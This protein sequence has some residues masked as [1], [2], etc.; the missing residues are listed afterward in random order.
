MS[1]QP[2]TVRAL[3]DARRRLRDAA[4]ADHGV[5][6]SAH[7]RANAD[8]ADAD[9]AVDAGLS[10]AIGALAAARSVAD[11]DRVH[12]HLDDDRAAAADAHALVRIAASAADDA[13]QRLVARERQLRSVEKL[14]ERMDGER[15]RSEAKA[16]QRM[17]DDHASRRG[18]A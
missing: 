13:A 16:D 2:R 15:A 9:A 17:T 11:L 4:A 1:I 10:G 18:G 8:A 7:A 14:I 5:A 6:S 3:R 12:A